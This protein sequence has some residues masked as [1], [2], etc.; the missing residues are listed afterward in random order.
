VQETR[1]AREKPLTCTNH[2]QTLSHKVASGTPQARQGYMF[3]HYCLLFHFYLFHPCPH[4]IKKKLTVLQL[5]VIP[6]FLLQV[7]LLSILAIF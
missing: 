4:M 6:I 1:V 7:Q 5:K 2:L 3:N